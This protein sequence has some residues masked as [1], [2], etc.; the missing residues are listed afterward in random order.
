MSDQARRTD[1]TQSREHRMAGKQFSLFHVM[2]REM[3]FGPL[4]ATSIDLCVRDLV[5]VSR[6]AETTKIIAERVDQPFAGFNVDPFPPARGALTSARTEL[7]RATSAAGAARH[8]HR[9]TAFA[10]CRGCRAPDAGLKVI[11]HRHSFVKASPNGMSLGDRIRR[12]FRKRRYVQ[13]AGIVHVSE[14]CATAFAQA[15]PDLL[16]PS[17]VVHNGLDFA[18]WNPS[19]ERSKEILLVGRCAPEK[20]VLEA[21]EAI[22]AV[23]ETFPDWRA[24]FMLSSIE[25]KSR[26]FQPAA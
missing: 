1:G 13:L 20:G 17:C 6:F 21:A 16:V 3:Y 2:P 5:A 14:A 10:E 9:P 23:L 25:Q 26:L 15:W 19:A 8:C 7:C 24:R 12:A 11:L 18:D 22:V 4:K